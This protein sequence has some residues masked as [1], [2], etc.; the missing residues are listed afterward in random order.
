MVLLNYYVKYE[1]ILMVIQDRKVL[2][3]KITD[4]MELNECNL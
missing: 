1:L 4:L 3:Y 2:Y